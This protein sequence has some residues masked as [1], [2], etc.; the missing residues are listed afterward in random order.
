MHHHFVAGERA[1]VGARAEHVGAR[2][3]ERD[4]HGCFPSAGNGGATQTAPTASW[5][6]LRVS[7]HVLIWSGVERD[8]AAAAIDEPRQ[9]QAEVLADRRAGRRDIA[10]L[11]PRPPPGSHR[12]GVASAARRRRS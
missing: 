9:M 10:G 4:V 8:V 12:P 6:P 3:V 7:S 11:R 1:V 2:L 5:R